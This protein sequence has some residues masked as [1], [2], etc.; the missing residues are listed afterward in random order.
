M[1]NAHALIKTLQSKASPERSKI[2]ASFFKTGEN[3]YGAGDLFLGIRVPTIREEIKDYPNLEMNE[4]EK[5]LHNPF[6]EIRLA[7][8]L[9]L[10]QQFQKSDVKA[11]QTI[12]RFYLKNFKYVNNWDLVDS[13]APK[14]I[15]PFLTE[16][17]TVPL[18]KWSRSPRLWTRRIAIIATLNAIQRKRFEDTLTT[19]TLLLK[20]E[21]DLIHKAAGWMLREVGKREQKPLHQ[22]LNTHAAL[23]PRTMLR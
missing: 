5:L 21:E 8:L 4:V 15:G 6:H 9:I 11:Q 14:I 16:G 12:Y 1:K 7:A 20:D 3:Q 22:F 10:V 23:M 18:H 19:A 13:S 2:N 17:H